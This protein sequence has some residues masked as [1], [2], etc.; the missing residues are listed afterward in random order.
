MSLM[1]AFGAGGRVC[2]GTLLAKRAKHNSAGVLMTERN[3]T[4]KPGR[5]FG[6]EKSQIFLPVDLLCEL[7]QQRLG[8]SALPA[9]RLQAERVMPLGQANVFVVAQ[10]RTMEIFR[11]R[12]P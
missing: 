5:R 8:I 6:A 11:R 1:W 2:A 9:E 3:S 7:R 12:Y 10:Q 4:R